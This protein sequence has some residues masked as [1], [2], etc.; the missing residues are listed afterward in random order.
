VDLELTDGE[1]SEELENRVGTALMALWRD[2]RSEESF[3]ALYAFARDAVLRWIQSLLHRGSRHLDP[4]ELLQDTFVNVFRYP[5]GFRDEHAGSFRVWVR[6]IAG[7]IVRRAGARA[8]RASLQELPEGLQEPEAGKGGPETDAI[9]TEQRDELR[10][11]WVL[12]LVHY[13]RAWEKLADRDRHALEMVEVDGRSYEE[14]G[15]ILQVRRSNMKMIIFRARKRI[16]ARMRAA[17]R[18]GAP[19]PVRL[20]LAG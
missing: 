1:T 11:A 13:R 2:E 12:F 15:R 18:E 9:A 19:A 14:A 16:T 6:T 10:V 8:G 7:N 17:M 20:R 4:R 5:G 3:E